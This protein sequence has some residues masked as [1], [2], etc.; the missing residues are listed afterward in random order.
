MSIPAKICSLPGLRP[1]R[2]RDHFAQLFFDLSFRQTVTLL[3]LELT[4]AP[5]PQLLRQTAA[6]YQLQLHYHPE[7]TRYLVHGGL[8]RHARELQTNPA[9]WMP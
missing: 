3:E 9:E 6:F 2:R 8:Q 7:A 5:V 4:P 1:W